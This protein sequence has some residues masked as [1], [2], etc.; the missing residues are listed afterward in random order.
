MFQGAGVSGPNARSKA[1][2]D[3]A[4]AC[5]CGAAAHHTKLE[6]AAALLA[7]HCASTCMQAVT[8]V[9][10]SG[11]DTSELTQVLA[12]QQALMPNHT[13]VLGKTQSQ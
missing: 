10:A 11:G 12:Q 6:G 13:N 8:T 4:W 3:G 5:V 7:P 9:F 1:G 2:Q